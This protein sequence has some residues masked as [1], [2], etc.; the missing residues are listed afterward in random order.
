MDEDQEQNP[1]VTHTRKNKPRCGLP[2]DLES[3]LRLYVTFELRASGRSSKGL[4]V[5]SGEI[6]AN[7]YISLFFCGV[8]AHE[9][10]I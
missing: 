5:N 6:S 7:P 2:R 8:P 4:F 10:S 9:V 3:I 1:R